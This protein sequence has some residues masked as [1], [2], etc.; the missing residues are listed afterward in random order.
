MK[1]SSDSVR[2]M[3]LSGR[4]R[5]VAAR[6]AAAAAILMSYLIAL[7]G[8]WAWASNTPQPPGFSSARDIESALL[9]LLLTLLVSFPALIPGVLALWWLRGEPQKKRLARAAAAGWAGFIMGLLFGLMFVLVARNEKSW[10]EDW[11][12]VALSALFVL[13]QGTLGL[14]A[15]AA[16][17]ATPAKSGEVAPTRG[18]ATIAVSVVS[19][20]L[21]GITLLI[22]VSLWRRCPTRDVFTPVGGLQTLNTAMNTYAST[23]SGYPPSLKVLGAPAKMSAP[24]CSGAGL[25][26][27]YLADG[28]RGGY[29]FQYTPGP[30][31]REAATAGCPRGADA[32]T[33]TAR[34]MKYG[35]CDQWSYFTDES[36]VIRG[37]QENRSATAQ[38]KPIY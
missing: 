27:E 25:T 21:F 4:G 1:A 32:Y 35:R 20:G 30:L 5:L 16:N 38:D 15:G 12:F 23:Y 36:G 26:D 6:G 8:V 34:P 17:R 9:V 37:T 28:K 18:A 3:P 31:T 33:L 24:E 7:P 13:A 2:G 14:S 29:V 11:G 10:D 19:C 22:A